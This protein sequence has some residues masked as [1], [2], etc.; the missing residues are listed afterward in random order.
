V[1]IASRPGGYVVLSYTVGA[2]GRVADLEVVESSPSGVFDGAAQAA[3]RKWLYEPR[4]ENGVAVASS[5]RARL[6]F[7]PAN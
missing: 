2:N 5:A 4:K 1:S 7:E 6:V 3:V